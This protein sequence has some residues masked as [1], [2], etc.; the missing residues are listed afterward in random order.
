MQY[1]AV[2]VV[3]CSSFTAAL[4]QA[5][6]PLRVQP[7]AQPATDQSAPAAPPPPAPLPDPRPRVVPLP[8][9]A[10]VPSAGSTGPAPASA[11]EDGVP[12]KPGWTGV[13]FSLG[14]GS[15]TPPRMAETTVGLVEAGAEIH[16]ERPR[17][18]MRP[19]ILLR[20]DLLVISASEMGRSAQPRFD[21][22]VLLSV[23]Y[24]EKLFGR[25]AAGPLACYG[26]ATPGVDRFRGGF[27][28]EANLG[29]RRAVGLYAEIRKTWGTGTPQVEI[30]GK[31]IGENVDVALTAGLRLDLALLGRLN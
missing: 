1:L 18:S 5:P 30:P 26:V 27:V 17:G 15:M 28:V 29:W 22:S 7:K 25:L 3:L 24:G 20:P 10:P 31:D 6:S 14:F 23:A 16:W 9:P 4:A 19:G 11:E 12:D 2:A 8:P 21:L 13:V